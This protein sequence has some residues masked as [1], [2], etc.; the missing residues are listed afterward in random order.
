MSGSP[1][2]LSEFPEA[3]VTTGGDAFNI[4]I[5]LIVSMVVIVG[6]AYLLAKLMSNRRL[7]DWAKSEFLQVLVSAALV[8]GLYFLMAP[9]TG[10]IIIAFNSLVPDDTVEIPM[11]GSITDGSVTIQTISADGCSAISSGKIPD[12]TVLCYSFNYL[13]ALSSQIGGLIYRMMLIN[14]IM[15]IISKISIDVIIIEITP[16]SGISSIVQVFNN[17]IQSLIFLGMAVNVGIALLYFIAATALNIFLPIGVILRSFFATRRLGGLLIGIAVGLYLV[18]PL[19]IAL[20]AIAVESAIPQAFTDF[21]E[22]CDSV[23]ALNPVTFFTEE[24]DLLS[25]ESWTGY[26]ENFET[27]VGGFVE[28]MSAIPELMMSIISLLVVQI[29]FLPIL[30][31]VLTIIAIKELA[32]LFGSETNMSRFEV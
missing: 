17:M 24:G 14:T 4:A 20:N 16:L 10:V 23:Q 1:D 6:I 9:A 30:S 22:F 12:E 29:I 32:S 2:L 31:M 18:F 5:Y 25:S 8:G 19:T 28:T 15:D 27:A 7:E 11:F 13:G 26:L 3:G 21:A